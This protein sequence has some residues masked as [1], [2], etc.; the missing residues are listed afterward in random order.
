MPGQ[1]ACRNLVEMYQYE[2]GSYWVRIGD[3]GVICGQFAFCKIK[4][5]TTNNK[6]TQ[7]KSPVAAEEKEKDGV[8]EL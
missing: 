1:E 5:Q 6:N 8:G 7:T 3:A 4:Q 2:P